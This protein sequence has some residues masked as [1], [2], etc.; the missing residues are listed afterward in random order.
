[1]SQ[2]FDTDKPYPSKTALPPKFNL[3]STRPPR[4]DRTLAALLSDM[5][6]H[7]EVCHHRF[8]PGVES[9]KQGKFEALLLTIIANDNTASEDL[10]GMVRQAY[11]EDRRSQDEDFIRAYPLTPTVIA[12][13]F[14]QRA[15][16]A[17]IEPSDFEMAWSYTADCCY[18]TGAAVSGSTFTDVQKMER[19]ELASKGAK[20]KH[21][22]SNLRITYA[23]QLV[24][25]RC[26]T[27][28]WKTK[29]EAACSIEDDVNKFQP[30]VDLDTPP[31]KPS[32]MA[33]VGHKAI[34]NWLAR[35][36][37]RDAFFPNQESSD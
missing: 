9:E 13:T 29:K 22:N 23:Y 32:A 4:K 21:R 16:R 11:R 35:M 25:D 1:M 24:R 18:W 19:T 5:K 34:L 8:C 3:M 30:P 7:L 26:P 28:G 33:P 31:G 20:A 2:A 36:P 12:L 27:G 10:I 14:W 37:D 17:C 6:G 15:M